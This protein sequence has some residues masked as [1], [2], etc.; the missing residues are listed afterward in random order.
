MKMDIDSCANLSWHVNMAFRE[1]LLQ[2]LDLTADE[3]L[4]HVQSEEHGGRHYYLESL[5]EV[6]PDTWIDRGPEGS[7]LSRYCLHDRDRTITLSLS[8]RAEGGTDW[9]HWPRLSARRS[10]RSGWMSSTPSA[11]AGWK[12]FGPPPALPW[13]PRGFATR[14]NP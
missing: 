13:T 11:P 9:P 3:T 1:L 6:F 5:I 8:P 4:T 7:A 14:S 2:T 10:A 12:D